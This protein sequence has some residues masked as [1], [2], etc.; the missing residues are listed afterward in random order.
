[1]NTLKECQERLLISS[2]GTSEYHHWL[3]ASMM[4]VLLLVLHITLLIQVAAII[5]DRRSCQM[6]SVCQCRLQYRSLVDGLITTEVVPPF[7]CPKVGTR[8]SAS[9]FWSS[10]QTVSLREACH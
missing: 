6:V 3:H 5:T 10:F 8:N 1:M 2:N 9:V 4:V 7:Y